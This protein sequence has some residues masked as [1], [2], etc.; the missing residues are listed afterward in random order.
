MFQRIQPECSKAEGLR[1]LKRPRPLPFPGQWTLAL[2][3]NHTHPFMPTG[4]GFLTLAQPL[5]ALMRLFVPVRL[6]L[7]Q[8]TFLRRFAPRAL[9][10]FHATMDALA[11]LLFSL[12]H[13]VG[14]GRR[15]WRRQRS[16]FFTYTVFQPLRLQPPHSPR[17]S[18]LLS[19]LLA[20]ALIGHPACA[21]ARSHT[22]K[23]SA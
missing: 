8:S 20:P 11:P 16:P 15:L 6:Y 13:A 7:P 22:F 9:P 17:P 5:W 3:A 23:P 18:L 21:R 4:H 12:G 14:H 2:R 19:V 1:H 10:R